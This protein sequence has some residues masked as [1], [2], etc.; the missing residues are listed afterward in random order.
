MRVP[1][2]FTHLSMMVPVNIVNISKKKEKSSRVIQNIQNIM[3]IK[4]RQLHT[5][6]IPASF[7]YFIFN[8]NLITDYIE[9]TPTREQDFNL[10]VKLNYR[11]LPVGPQRGKDDRREYV[12]GGGL[13]GG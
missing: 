10:S 9:L 1:R 12:R 11:S 4:F 6:N 3:H 5:G 2:G 8:T 13:H 7:V